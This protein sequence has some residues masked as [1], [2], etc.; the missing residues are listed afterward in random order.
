MAQFTWLPFFD[1]ML[2]VICQRY[3]KHTLCEV[4]HKIFGK[5]GGVNDRFADGTTGPLQEIDPLT[6]LGYFN[7]NNTLEKKIGYCEAAKKALQLAAEVPSDFD[8]VP[9]LDAR[10]SWFFGWAKNRKP[11]DIDNLWRFSKAL[12]ESALT[13]ELLR[14]VLAIKGVGVAK[15]TQLMFICKPQRFVSLDST[16]RNY[17]HTQNVEVALDFRDS[18]DCYDRYLEILNRIK[19]HF[20]NRPFYE[21]SYAAYMHREAVPPSGVQYWVIAPGQQARLWDDFVKDSIIAIGWDELGD[22]NQYEDKNAL[23]SAIQQAYGA[24]TSKRN[25]ASVCHEFSKVMKIDDYVFA[26][27]GVSQIVGFGKITSDYRH[28]PSRSEHHAVRDVQWIS[29]GNWEILEGVRPALKTL[30][31]VTDNQSFLDFILPLVQPVIDSKPSS[32]TRSDA[33][34]ELFIGEDRFSEIMDALSHKKNLVLQGAPGVGKTFIAKRIAYALIG[35][36]DDAGIQMIQF[37]QSYS[38]EDFIQG[39]R[40]NDNGTFDLKNG[41]FY[42]FCKKAQRNKE[43]KYVFIID[44]I[45]RGNLS[46]IF[47]E[48]M[49]LIEADKR[50]DRFA[51]PLT[52][53]RSADEVFYLPQNLYLIGTMNTA[54]RSLA[55]VDYALR[56]RFAF[57]DLEPC[58][59]NSRFRRHLEVSGVQSAIIDKIVKRMTLLNQQISE[60]TKNLGRG[61]RI[62]HSFFCPDGNNSEVGEQWYSL[63]IRHEIGPLL[64]E[65]WLDD[66]KKAEAEIDALLEI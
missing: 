48:L 47:G 37:H 32:Y 53:A 40:P 43:G 7:R 24:D 3:D 46:K 45:N 14:D 58:F 10:N 65:Y 12:K 56:R 11:S 1:E 50:G 42:E 35:Y 20:P 38:Y 13:N 66:S 61:Y 64:K 22:L 6:F 16:N 28:D 41:V 57:I 30:T 62:G 23:Q 26:K 59:E 19:A 8:S 27:K 17:F 54:D 51:V 33:L 36:R 29:K 9:S 31:N 34:R 18:D 52:Y 5:G 39:Y 44:E 4:F 2:S 55:M 21:L 15:L 25:S 60:D 49:M 63:V